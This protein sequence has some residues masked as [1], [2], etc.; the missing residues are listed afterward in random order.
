MRTFRGKD[1]WLNTWVAG[2]TGINEGNKKNVLI[3]LMKIRSAFESYDELWSSDK[4]SDTAKK[5]KLAHRNKFGDI[6]QPKS[7]LIGKDVFNP[8][9]YHPPVSEHVHMDDNGWHK[10]IKYIAY[11]RSAALL[12]GDE[13]YSFLWDKPLLFHSPQLHRGQKKDD[14]KSLLASIREER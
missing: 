9:K 10:D 6:F 2:F 4:L 1:S 3:Y 5:A 12:I 14:L 13:Q 8:Q 11:G 7:K